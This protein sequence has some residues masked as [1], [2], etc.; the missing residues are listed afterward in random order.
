MLLSTHT[1]QLNFVLVMLLY[2]H[3]EA[4]PEGQ[5][6]HRQLYSKV[7]ELTRAAVAGAND[8]T[9]LNFLLTNEDF[10]FAGCWS[11]SRPG[12]R[13]FNGLHYL[14]RQPPFAQASLSDC[15]YTIDFSTVTNPEDRVAVIATAPLTRDECWC[16]MQRGELY[17][18]QDGRPFSNGE[19]WAMYA[20]QGIREYTDFC[21]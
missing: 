18:F 15:D 1:K 2:T 14:V 6:S 20:E 9:I 19:D 4:F 12:S 7:L 8:L 16:Q 5:P 11:G 13:V 3:Q 10:M 21:I 17:V